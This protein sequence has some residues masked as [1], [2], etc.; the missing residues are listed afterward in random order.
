[1]KASLFALSIF[2]IFL[3]AFVPFFLSGCMIMAA[4]CERLA[5]STKDICYVKEAL[6]TRDQMFCGKVFEQSTRDLCYARLAALPNVLDIN[7]CEK[8]IDRNTKGACYCDV[9]KQVRRTEK[10]GAFGC[11]QKCPEIKW[12]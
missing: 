7:I 12:E 9:C 1:M 6:R 4:Q 2:F 3:L 5:G 8:I 11:A 10:W